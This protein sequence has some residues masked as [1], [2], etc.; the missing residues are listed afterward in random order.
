M[1]DQIYRR[2]HVYIYKCMYSLLNLCI[3]YIESITCPVIRELS[4]HLLVCGT[5]VL[6]MHSHLQT[7]VQWTCLERPLPSSDGYRYLTVVIDYLT[8]Y[9]IAYPSKS[10]AAEEV[11]RQ[12]ME[13]IVSKYGTPTYLATDNGSGINM[14]FLKLTCHCWHLGSFI[15]VFNVAVFLFNVRFTHETQ[16]LR[17][18]SKVRYHF[19]GGI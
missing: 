8:K 7:F 2:L 4:I 14:N 6:A 19:V 9:T 12:F 13:N 15:I 11:S 5:A 10:I 18:R 17:K 3:T 1:Y 16:S